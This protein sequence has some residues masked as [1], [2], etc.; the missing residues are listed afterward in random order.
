[1][2]SISAALGKPLFAIRLSLFALP[3]CHP[4]HGFSLNGGSCFRSFSIHSSPFLHSFVIP[5]QD[6]SPS[7][8]ICSWNGVGKA[9]FTEN[10]N[11]TFVVEF[12]GDE[13]SVKSLSQENCILQSPCF[14]DFTCK[15]FKTLEL[16]AKLSLTLSISCDHARKV[17]K[18][19]GLS[20]SLKN[21]TH[22]SPHVLAIA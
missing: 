20:Q 2:E 17:F 5:T 19:L 8:G 1:V 4:D 18:I 12:S 22:S 14:E 15:V 10:G 3:C 21:I 6:S 11:H 7:E 13:L 9:N 16:I